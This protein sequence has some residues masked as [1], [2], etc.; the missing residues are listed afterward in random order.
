MNLHPQPLT[1]PVTVRQAIGY[2]D[3]LGQMGGRRRRQELIDAWNKCPPGK[4]LRKGV[5]NVSSFESAKLHPG[6]PSTSQTAN[7][8][9]WHYATPR[10]LTIEEMALIGSFDPDFLW[11]AKQ[12]QCKRQIGNSVPPLFMR[13]IARHIREKILAVISKMDRAA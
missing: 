11:P 4:S 13:A 10:S 8:F 1:R 2:L 7:H 6:R 12:E 3:R 5:P 9:H